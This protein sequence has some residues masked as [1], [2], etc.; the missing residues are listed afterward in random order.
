M[1]KKSQRIVPISEKTLRNIVTRIIKESSNEK[2]NKTIE[3]NER[4]EK[5]FSDAKKVLT[6]GK[7]KNKI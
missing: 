5:Q 4:I 6:K 3:L 7:L 2:V 1:K